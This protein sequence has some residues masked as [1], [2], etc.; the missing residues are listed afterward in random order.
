MCKHDISRYDASKEDSSV[1]PG[2]TECLRGGGG[3]GGDIK[4][5]GTSLPLTV[6][7]GDPGTRAATIVVLICTVYIQYHAVVETS[8]TRTLRM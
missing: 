7:A 2:V 5:L 8:H 4:V 1:L 6:H 3:A